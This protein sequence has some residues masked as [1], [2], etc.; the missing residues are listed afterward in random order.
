MRFSDIRQNL[1][2][3]YAGF[4]GVKIAILGDTPTQ[5]LHQALK[6]CAYDRSL[7]PIVF[8]AGVD[9]IDRQILDAT[10]E[11]YRFRP[12]YVLLF[13]SAQRLLSRFYARP[14]EGQ[15]TFGQAHLEHVET[16][17]RALDLHLN[18][19]VIYCNFGE[20]DDGVYGSY[21]NKT[22]LSFS[23]QIRA[24]NLGL[25][26]LAAKMNNLFVADLS[27]LQNRAGRN[28]VFSTATYTTAGFAYAL[29]FWPD[30]ATRVLDIVLSLRGRMHKAVVV[31]LDNTLWGGVVGDDG[32]EHIQIGD[33]GIGR[34]FSELQAWL[35]QLKERGILLAVCSKNYES[36]A[37]EVF[38]KHPH[39]VLRLDDFAVFVAN[40]ENKVDNIR[41]IQRVLGIGFDSIVYLDDSPFERAMLKEAIPSLTVPELPE[42]PADYLESLSSLNLFETGALTGSDEAR[43]RQYRLE[44]RRMSLQKTYDSEAAFLAGLEMV[45]AARPFDRFH[46][47]RIAQLS[48]R[49]N[50]FNLRTVRYTERDV[51]AIMEDPS[52]LTRYFTLADRVGDYGLVSVVVLNKRDESLFIENWFMSCRV[53][54]RGMEELV[55][56]VV[57]RLARQ[58]GCTRVI[59]EYIATEKNA[60]VKDHYRRLG[61]RAENALWIATT[62]DYLDMPTS[63]ALS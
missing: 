34:A 17:C 44:A 49:S 3:D 23:Y 2:K 61:F 1:K 50:Q 29:D 33:L 51:E 10:S 15:A 62:D 59:G 11:L 9:Q 14:R 18:S 13:E 36:V 47:P 6:G 26:D 24:V 21:A 31:D 55:L 32:L 42:D 19:P 7:N 27:S 35:K 4:P 8:E 52:Y 63:I 12:D 38:E 57:M 40:W 60:L 25:M 41:H 16:L 20:I 5:F 56:N 22:R 54:H 46:L 37:R 58:N 53:L 39:M 30:L 43:T 45:A 28:Q 48:Q